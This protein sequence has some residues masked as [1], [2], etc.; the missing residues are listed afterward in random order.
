[1]KAIDKTNFDFIDSEISVS[2]LER[3]KENIVIK[4]FFYDNNLRVFGG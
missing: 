4:D 2:F 1:M 3:L